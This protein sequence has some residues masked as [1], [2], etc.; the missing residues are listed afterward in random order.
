MK[1]VARIAILATFLCNQKCIAHPFFHKQRP[2][3]AALAPPKRR[4]L[5]SISSIRGG[6]LGPIK[7]ETLAKT[8]AVGAAMDTTCFSFEPRRALSAM[9]VTIESD[10][11]SEFLLRDIGFHAMTATIACGLS[12]WTNLSTEAILG[13]ALCAR[14]A[15]YALAL[16]TGSSGK[17]GPPTGTN[18]VLSGAGVAAAVFSLLT[19]K[20]DP[21]MAARVVSALYLAHGALLRLCPGYTFKIFSGYDIVAYGDTEDELA[22][23]MF[24]FVGDY[25]IVVQL[26]VF[27][28]A[29]GTDPT[30]AIGYSSLASVF[31]MLD[32]LF[33]F[34]LQT[35]LDFH[36]SW[37]V[38]T[39]AFLAAL[40]GG[41][42]I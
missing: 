17:T 20:G 42:L 8:Y 22:M 35:V 25:K 23:T 18:L 10:S 29:S 33:G 4:A 37:V 1:L 7:A 21:L 12:L 2:S 24:S 13:R 26:L 36:W 27:L 40:A 11:S 19:G 41:I 39:L 30:K 5:E 38:A 34:K 16:F 31:F 6:D 28:L 32:A 3:G 9:G 14:L 15:F